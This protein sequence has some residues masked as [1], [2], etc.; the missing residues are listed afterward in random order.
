MNWPLLMFKLDVRSV[1]CPVE[2]HSLPI[3]CE[4]FMDLLRLKL[5]GAALRGPSPCDTW[6]SHTLSRELPKSVLDVLLNCQ[7]WI[8]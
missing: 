3:V 2:L 8:L 5:S 7:A 4:C 1:W 6:G